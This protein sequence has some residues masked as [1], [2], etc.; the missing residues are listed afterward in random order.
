VIRV[1]DHLSRPGMDSAPANEIM[2]DRIGRAV[3]KGRPLDDRHVYFLRH[4]LL[5][6]ELMD[7]G[8]GYR[9]AHA[10]ALKTHPPGQ[11]YDLDVIVQFEEFG[12]WWRKM[13][14][15]GPR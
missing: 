1:A 5:E 11:N 7:R 13:N 2:L 12:Q 6:A 4:E 3:A 10:K 15:L 14:G 9:A 8:V